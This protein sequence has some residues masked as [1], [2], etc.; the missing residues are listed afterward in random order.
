V[1]ASRP[2]VINLHPSS[3][4]LRRGWLAWGAWLVV[5][6]A[7]LLQDLRGGVL[8]FALLL[9]APFWALWIFWL[10][11]RL[12]ATWRRL[13]ADRED[14]HGHYYEFDGQRIRI[15]FDG[16]ALRYVADDVFD[17]LRIESDA[18]RPERV[19][20]IAGRDGLANEPLRRLLCFSDRGLDAWLERRTDQQASKF[21]RWLD[22][23]VR[24]P[25]RRRRERAS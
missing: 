23:Q 4:T 20:Q 2:L 25:S 19:R 6:S 10:F 7:L 17:A 18:R 5:A 16:D 15:L 1:D 21:R 12:L 13:Q 22:T 3:T 8:T 14:W 24:E 11:Y 9:S